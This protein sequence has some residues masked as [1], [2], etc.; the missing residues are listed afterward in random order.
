MMT[1]G[2]AQF[3][4][5]LLSPAIFVLGIYSGDSSLVFFGI[6]LNLPFTAGAWAFGTVFVSVLGIKSAYL[7]GAFIGIA[8]QLYL[9]FLIYNRLG[10][11]FRG[12]KST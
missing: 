3:A 6:F 11:W 2:K 12:R 4:Y 1:I 9:L 7:F 10:R 5:T 8:I